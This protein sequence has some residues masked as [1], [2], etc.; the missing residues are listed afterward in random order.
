[1][2]ESYDA[3]VVGAGFGG[4][5]TA[6]H[7]AANGARVCLLEALTY[8][9]GCASTFRRH[10][11]RFEAGATLFSGFGEGQLF[12]RWIHEHE[13]DVTIDWLD[14]VVSY[15]APGLTL[16]IPGDRDAFRERL[17]HATGAP[18]DALRGFLQMQGR[19]ADV[20]WDVLAQPG[21][22]PPFTASGFGFHLKSALRWARLLRWIGRP[23]R[24]VLEKHGLAEYES[25]KVF[26]D[27]LCQITV[28]CTTDRAEAPLGMATLDYLFRGTGHVRGGIGS[29]A[30]ELSRAIERRGGNVRFACRAFGVRPEGNGWVVDT[31]R[32]TLRAP[33][34]ALNV[35]PQDARALLG[36][37]V[38][39]EKHMRQ[40]SEPLDRAWGAC[41]LYVGV[42]P[43]DGADGPHHYQ[44]VLDEGQPLHEGNHVFCSISGP[45]DGERAPDG[46]RTMTVST[47]ADPARCWNES[48]AADYVARVQAQMRKTLDARLPEWM[49]GAEKVMPASPRTFQRFTARHRGLVGGVPKV[50]GLHNYRRLGPRRIGRGLYLVGDSVFPGQSTLA[51]ALGGVK[52]ADQILRR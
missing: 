48:E 10:G 45:R 28:Q 22:L 36:N 15:R 43:P 34:V 11:Y 16:D 3:I 18:P 23:V 20:L 35:L 40:L 9:G 8:P 31:R 42:R 26:F 27:A 38:F 44:L 14:P 47:H 50:A 41:M 5:G 29:L 52:A 24:K 12:Q 6:M 46:Q 17:Q 51:T 25:L 39:D 21:R 2:V 49:A 13:M 32:G 19:T 30:W 1:M 7:L 4:L 33:A 37:S